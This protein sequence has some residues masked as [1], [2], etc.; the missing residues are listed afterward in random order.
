VHGSKIAYVLFLKC[1]EALYCDGCFSEYHTRGHR[2]L[3]S[4]KR[5]RFGMKPPDEKEG[6][7]ELQ[8]FVS[9][10]RKENADPNQILDNDPF[11][12]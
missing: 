7:S 2:K 4:Y 8:K 10:Q 6:E 3:H 11:K 12:T 9:S 5:I 1:K